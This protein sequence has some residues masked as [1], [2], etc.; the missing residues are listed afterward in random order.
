MPSLQLTNIKFS[1]RRAK[2]NSVPVS[3]QVEIVLAT[4]KCC[5][6]LDL[7][8][9]A[10]DDIRLFSRNQTANGSD[11]RTI[12]NIWETHVVIYDDL[13]CATSKH[14]LPSAN[15]VGRHLIDDSDSNSVNKAHLSHSAIET[16]LTRVRSRI[17]H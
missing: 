5:Q 6:N 8:S 7:R 16:D 12:R 3:I 14:D 9:E 10:F 1:Q 2:S 15:E 13:L 17:R 4:V 11:S